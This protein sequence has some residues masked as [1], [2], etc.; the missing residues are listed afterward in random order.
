MPLRT[1]FGPKNAPALFQRLMDRVLRK[2]RPVARAFID[3]TIVHARG[4]ANHLEALRSVFL[5]LRRHN[6]KE[7]DFE[8]KYRKGLINMNADGLSRSPQPETDDLTGARV[9]EDPPAEET[10]ETGGGTRAS[11]LLAWQAGPA[12]EPP[13]GQEPLTIEEAGGEI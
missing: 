1:P 4:F 5:E 10:A 8:V 13:E 12:E 6:I 7:F 11:A 2:L 9:H 3:D